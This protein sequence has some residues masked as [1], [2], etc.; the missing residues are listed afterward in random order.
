M[1]AVI[2]QLAAQQAQDPSAFSSD[3]LTK[4]ILE[5]LNQDV[6][7]LY[8]EAQAEGGEQSDE[9]DEDGEDDAGG[10]GSG[11]GDGGRKVPRV[12]LPKG[13]KPV[14]LWKAAHEVDRAPK[15]VRARHTVPMA[16][17]LC[18]TTRAASCATAAAAVVVA[19]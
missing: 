12:Q 5:R 3:A 4:A 14:D 1:D 19:C 13:P 6:A 11:N 17:Y 9:E 16:C 15:E 10:D 7:R 18:T 2:A 8:A